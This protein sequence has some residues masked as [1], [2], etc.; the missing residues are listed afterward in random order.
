ML[1]VATRDKPIIKAA[2]VVVVRLGARAAFSLASLPVDLEIS[3]NG[4]PMTLAKLAVN[5]GL[6][7]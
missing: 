1:T 5:S 6:T 4:Q 2:A 3:F 7:R